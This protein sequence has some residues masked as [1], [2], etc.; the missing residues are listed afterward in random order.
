MVKNGFVFIHTTA[1]IIKL[2]NLV[3]QI[4]NNL[5]VLFW[6]FLSLMVLCQTRQN[7]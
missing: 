7:N 2:T 4:L 3:Y 6:L 5:Q 1:K